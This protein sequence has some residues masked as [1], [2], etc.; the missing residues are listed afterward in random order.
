MCGPNL[1]DPSTLNDYTPGDEN[2]LD[3]G[4]NAQSGDGEAGEDATTDATIG[5]DAGEDGPTDA[6]M[7]LDVGS[8][9]TGAGNVVDSTA[10]DAPVDAA[11]DATASETGTQDAAV[12][13]ACSP[14]G[15]TV[16]MGNDSQVVLVCQGGQWTVRS[17]PCPS[18]QRCDSTVGD[19]RNVAPGCAGLQPGDTFCGAGEIEKCGVDLVTTTVV[20]TCGSNQTC[21]GSPG[22]VACTCNA[23]AQCTVAGG[24]CTGSASM[25]T[26]AVDSDGCLFTS[27]T[28]TCTNGACYGPAGSAQC[29]TNACTTAGTT[30]QGNTPV[31]CAAGP[32][33]CLVQTQGT[34][35][36]GSTPACV[37]GVCT[38]VSCTNQAGQCP[39]GYCCNSGT[40]VANAPA[41]CGAGG[42]QCTNCA[43]DSRG[44]AC[45][46][47][48]CGCT[49]SADC[50]A[51]QGV[52]SLCSG[53]RCGCTTNAD[54]TTQRRGAVCSAM[55]GGSNICGCNSAADCASSGLTP[56]GCCQQVCYQNGSTNGSLLCDN[57]TFVTPAA[58]DPCVNSCGAGLCCDQ[59][60]GAA[61]LGTCIAATCINGACG[62][63]GNYCCP[64]SA[65]AQCAAG[66]SCVSGICH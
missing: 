1:V 6:T 38:S 47:G 50:S 55:G 32:D 17:P 53:N 24:T 29:C 34:P 44:E 35:C 23:D 48:V 15:A 21:T 33:G 49:S 43:T 5:A 30:C 7:G 39:A 56:G 9:D 51:D 8:R 52:G 27:G 46:N 40:C 3:A 19:C 62:S 54:C 45:V 14:A 22:S 58:G 57:G 60:A 10:P 25:V 63:G 2:K 13:A 65:G 4:G 16:C 41:T 20:K 12:D 26:C 66:Y 31:T 11:T 28:P 37:G 18:S 61:A 42:G 59:T 36:G 64:A